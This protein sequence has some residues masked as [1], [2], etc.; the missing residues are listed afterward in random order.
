MIPLHL[1][2]AEEKY[3]FILD[4]SNKKAMDVHLR[5]DNF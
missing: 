1:G 4:T 3:R 2:D 5:E